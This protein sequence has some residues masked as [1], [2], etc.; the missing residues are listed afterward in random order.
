[1][2]LVYE[3]ESGSRLYVK[4]APEVVLQ[5]STVE[6]RRRLAGRRRGGLGLQG[7]EGARR[8]RAP[9]SRRVR[10]RRC[11]RARSTARR[12]GRTAGPT[13]E[14]G[15]RRRRRG[16]LRRSPRGD[17]DGGPPDH[18]EGDRPRAR[19]ARGGD[20]RTRHASREASARR[21]PASRGRGR[22][23]HRGRCQ[24]CARPAAGGRR[25][26]RWDR[27]APRSPAR[28]PIS[29]SRTTT[30]RPS[31]PPFERGA[32]SP[33][34]SGSSSP[35]FSRRTW[36]RLLSSPSRSRPASACR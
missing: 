8:R 23:R 15:F 20:S 24:R 22:R 6:R 9:A 26:S 19:L 28:P 21:V 29:S 32:R 33:T 17:G 18:R 30:S 4:G 10:G 16:A 5:R 13:A 14:D 1:M 34:T 3:E 12:T 25:V 31:S 27:R 2:S 7:T 35:S 36:A 11:S